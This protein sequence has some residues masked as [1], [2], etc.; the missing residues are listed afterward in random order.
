MREKFLAV[1]PDNFKYLKTIDAAAFLVCLD[2]GSPNSEEERVRQAYLGNGFNRWQDKCAQF[3]VSANG[4]SGFI[5]EHGAIDGMTIGRL[6]DSI[7]QAIQNHEPE[8][9]EH[10]IPLAAK[11]VRLE[12][13]FFKSTSEIDNHIAILRE[14]YLTNTSAL[15][16]RLHTVTAFGVNY[17]MAAQS[18]VKAVID[19]TLQLAMRLYF[20]HRTPCWEAVSMSHYHKGRPE[21]MQA[22]TRPVADFCDAALNNSI[23]SR[24]KRAMLL[25]L[26]PKMANNMQNCQE[27]K[28]YLRLFD[29]LDVLWPQDE[30]KPL[31]FR[32]A[33]FW[34]NPFVMAIHSPVAG[35]LAGSGAY[36][37]QEPNSFWV[38]ISHTETWYVLLLFL[39][40]YSLTS[41]VDKIG[42]DANYLLSVRFAVTGPAG[43]KTQA[44]CE[45]LD[46]AAQII[47][48]ILDAKS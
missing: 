22:T 18:P 37:L 34:R 16:Y 28:S 6:W 3:L 46:E 12:E 39:F 9:S 7:H 17:L 31:L 29:L 15:E 24:E 5:L 8:V 19:A 47:K 44:F 1:N 32:E 27:G 48:Q 4:R 45:R 40:Y 13:Y 10:T 38:L 20:G 35:D 14:R 26:G 21:M 41:R 33:L 25:Q 42:Q 36:G 2:D 43:G 23:S 11:N 30:P